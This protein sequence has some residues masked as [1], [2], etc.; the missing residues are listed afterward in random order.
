MYDGVYEYID[1][2]ACTLYKDQAQRAVKL[3]EDIADGHVDLR[4]LNQ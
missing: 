4:K 2:P 3:C 1:R